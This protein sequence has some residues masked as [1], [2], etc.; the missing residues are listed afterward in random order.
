[1]P[2]P[3][4]GDNQHPKNF[5]T[6]NK[7]LQDRIRI[8]SV[9]VLSDEWA[10]LKKTVFDYRRSDG[11]WE[12]QTRQTYD[13]GDGAVILPYDRERQTVLMVRQFR[14][15]AYVTGHPEPLIEA[16]AGL[17]DEDDPET[18]IR[19]EAEEELGYR[20]RDVRRLYAPYMSPGS[21]TER[22]WFFVADYR[23][24]DRISEGGGSADEGEDI[25]VMELTLD[26]SLAMIES[27]DI[28]DAKTIML[29]QH[30][31]LERAAQR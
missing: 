23:P 3:P 22:L 21:V 1:L 2:R 7:P 17:L 20:L 11:T 8:R 24:A 19:R 27:G 13:R 26:K 18:C 31:A 9:E 28:I 30:L 5:T 10:V 4:I 14:Y 25:E 16:C 15:P 12:T 6:G 29:V